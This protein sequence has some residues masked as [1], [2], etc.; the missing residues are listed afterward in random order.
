MENTP[1]PLLPDKEQSG[2]MFSWN[3][4]RM[5]A[6][7]IITLTLLAAYRHLSM[8]IPLGIEDPAA[9]ADTL[10]QVADSLQ[11]IQ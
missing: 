3:F 1:N 10:L 8:G 11:L 2:M 9:A 4:V 5:S 7:L 6:I